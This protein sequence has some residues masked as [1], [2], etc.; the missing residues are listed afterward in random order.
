MPD[1]TQSLLL[2]VQDHETRLNMMDR[3]VSEGITEQRQ[4]VR[5]LHALTSRLDVYI[6]KHDQVSETHKRLWNQ[7]ENQEK[8]IDV[9]KE[10]ASANQPVIDGIRNLQ[11][12][13][14]WLIVSTVLSPAAIIGALAVFKIG[15]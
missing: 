4:L 1:E 13:L 15:Q 10:M 7:L 5:E 9:L 2:K 6:E 12:K 11:S 3:M 8:E 14:I